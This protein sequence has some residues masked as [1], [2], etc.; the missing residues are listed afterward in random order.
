MKKDKKKKNTLSKAKI[1][2]LA[3]ILSFLF[4]KTVKGDEGIMIV[5]MYIAPSG[6]LE[7][8]SL[9]TSFLAS[10][11][12]IPSLLMA[13]VVVILRKR[14]SKKKWPKVL[15]IIFVSLVIL[16]KVVSIIIDIIGQ[17]YY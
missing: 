2:L 15:L 6:P 7:L 1:A 4:T 11:L 17:R 12:M 8:A 10:I 5:N 14:K 9:L 16:L 13:V 3:P